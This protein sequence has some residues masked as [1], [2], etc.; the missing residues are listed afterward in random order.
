MKNELFFSIDAIDLL[1]MAYKSE[2]EK[3]VDMLTRKDTSLKTLVIE[4]VLEKLYE[5]S[6]SY[7]QFA[8]AF[9]KYGVSEKEN[10]LLDCL[11]V[12]TED[13]YDCFDVDEKGIRQAEVPANWGMSGIV[14]HAEY[15][16]DMDRFLSIYKENYEKD[17]MEERE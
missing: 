2:K 9:A 3:A 5:D 17:Q 8:Q 11:M 15:E 16:F 14:Y 4:H 7:R 10:E 6:Q 1:R 12:Y 13:F